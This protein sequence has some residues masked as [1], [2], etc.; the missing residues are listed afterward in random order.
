MK[1][2]LSSPSRVRRVL[3]THLNRGIPDYDPPHPSSRTPPASAPRPVLP[4]KKEERGIHWLSGK[5]SP[6]V[7]RG[8]RDG[9]GD[10]S[11]GVVRV[12]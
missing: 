1:P 3:F 11:P 8:F 12:H 2:D 4:N 9:G 5:G 7:C 10:G 6:G